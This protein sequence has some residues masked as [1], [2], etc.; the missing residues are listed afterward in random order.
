MENHV[1]STSSKTTS[2]KN[3]Y[4]F[5]P[6]IFKSFAKLHVREDADFA[7]FHVQNAQVLFFVHLMQG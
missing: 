4:E 6:F 3:L 1:S 7:A 2:G 5:V